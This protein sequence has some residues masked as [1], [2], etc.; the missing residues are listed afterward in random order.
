MWFNKTNFFLLF[1]SL[2]FLLVIQTVYF[3]GVTNIQY[4]SQPIELVVHSKPG[5]GADIMARKIAEIARTKFHVQ[6][7]IE[8]KPGSQG[9]TAMQYVLGKKK[10]GYTILTVTKSFISTVLVDASRVNLS[11]FTFFAHMMRDPEVL[12]VN[13]KASIRTLPEILADAKLNPGQQKWI[14]A[15][16]GGRDHLMALTCWNKLG[17]NGQWLDYK[18]APS[19]SLAMIRKEAP[20]FIGNFSDISGKESYL[21]IAAVADASRSVQFP[22]V[23]TF[24]DNGYDI[25]EYMWRGFAFPKGVPENSVRYMQDLMMKISKTQEWKEFIEGEGAQPIFIGYPAFQQQVDS[26]TNS[27]KQLLHQAGLIRDLVKPYPVDPVAIFVVC[28]LLSAGFLFILA[29]FDFRRINFTA[30]LASGL[31]AIGLLFLYETTLY[32]MPKDAHITSP[33]TL[34]RIYILFLWFSCGF[35]VFGETRK[36][37]SNI[38]KDVTNNKLLATMIVCVFSYFAGV[39]YA[40]FYLSSLVMLSASM[41]LLGYKNIRSNLTISLATITIL[42]VLFV[43]LLKIGLPEGILWI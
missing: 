12:I 19:A 26:E 18:D 24:K 3:H 5:A 35:L 9:I 25:Q 10:D 23:P 33:A 40:G 1:F 36:Q 34:P 38:K 43:L 7:Y 32:I 15:G 29:G 42:Y 30:W 21:Q 31:I 8:N 4:P 28:L 2:A 16:I 6:F 20:V 39:Y 22:D 41:Y 14:G 37:Q 11:N 27:T 17:I 13:K